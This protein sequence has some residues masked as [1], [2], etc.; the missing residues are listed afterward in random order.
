MNSTL[1]NLCT[2]DNQTEDKTYHKKT[3]KLKVWEKL[4]KHTSLQCF[5]L[6]GTMN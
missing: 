6:A 1:R 3:N 4:M 2:N 5:R